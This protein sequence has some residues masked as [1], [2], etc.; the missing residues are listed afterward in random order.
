[1]RDLVVGSGIAFE[2]RGTHSLKGVPDEWSLLAVVPAEAAQESPEVQLAK[3]ETP[4]PRESM[5][6]GDR[7]A[8]AVARRAPGV[9]RAANRRVTRRR[10]ARQAT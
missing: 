7:V 5:R 2:E 10:A 9:L 8:A 3:I 1:V 6:V 4:G